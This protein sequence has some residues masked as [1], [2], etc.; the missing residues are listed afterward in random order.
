[1]Q[2]L[3][4]EFASDNSR[5]G[6]RLQRLE[7]LNWGTFGKQAIWKIEPGGANSLLT[8]DIGSGKSTLVDAITTLLV[9]Y[10]KITYNRAAG[11]ETKERS[12]KSYVLGEYKN[13]KN[14]LDNSAKPEYLREE[15]EYTVLLACFF[16]EG[17]SQETT[18]AQVFWLRNDKPE[19]FFVVS[20]R[21]LSISEHFTKFG[22]DILQLKKKIKGLEHT[23]VYESFSDYCSRFRNIFGIRSEK[24]LELFYQT[25]SIKS[26]GNLTEFVRSHMIEKSDVKDKIEEL[27]RN[28]ENLTRLHE[29]VLKAKKQLAELQPLIKDAEAFESVNNEIKEMQDCL[30]ALPAFFAVQK[31]ELLQALIKEQNEQMMIVANTLEQLLA[32]LKK[33]HERELDINAA[34][35]G[36]KEGQRI[37]E[38]ER[39][40]S[41]LEL[42]KNDKFAMAREYGT[43][44]ATLEL[45]A[46]TNEE[47]FYQSLKKATAF[48]ESAAKEAGQLVDARD[49]I[50]IGLNKMTETRK[51]NDEELASLRQRKT[52]IPEA[53]LKLRAQILRDLDLNVHALPFAGELLKVRDEEQSW[54]GVIERVLHNF[55]LSVLVPEEHY[56][57]VSMYV[58]K[59]NLKGRLVYYR[60]P[61]VMKQADY[62]EASTSSMLN[63]VEIKS[64]SR[65]Y[66]WLNN[67]L[68]DNFNYECCESIEQFQREAKAITR[69]G[70]IKGRK[71]RHEKDDSRNILDRKNYILGW[72]NQEK[73]RAI[74]KELEGLKQ[75]IIAAEREMLSIENRQQKYRKREECLRDFVKFTKFGDIYW[76]KDAA[77]IE[78]LKQERK[79]LENTSDQMRELQSQLEKVQTDIED[80]GKERDENQEK[81]GRLQNVTENMN[82]SLTDCETVAV[83]ITAEEREKF[84]PKLQ[85]LMPRKEGKVE[86]ID[87][88]R[89]D[90]RKL[91]ESEKGRKADEEKILRDSIISR[92][93]RYKGT[94]KE[95]TTEVDAS[96]AS[97][98]EFKV[99]FKKLEDEDLPRYESRFKEE[100]NQGTINDIAMF[101]N[102][103]EY[104]AKDIEEKIRQINRSLHAIEYNPGTY[105]ELIA[106]KAI[107]IAVK[108]FQVQLRNCLENTLTDTELYNEEKFNKVKVILDRFN[109]AALADINWTSRVTDVRN[110]YT[111]AA[112][113]RYLEDDTIKEFYPDSSGKSGGQKEKL[114]YT[115][116]ASA[117]AYQFGLEWKQ[118]KSRSFRFVALDEAFGRSSDDST[119]YA[120][121]LFR[122]LD[123]QLLLVTPLQKINIIENYINTV[124]FVANETGDNSVVRDLTIH[125][126]REEKARYLAK[127]EILQ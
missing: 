13:I 30:D 2:N 46:A 57:R 92:M 77:E 38:I 102:Q 32:D 22:K 98:P 37:D 97:I 26:V 31:A 117:L 7:V 105:I 115:I 18:L 99:F 40:I 76:Q 55:G 106:D 16:N 121:D 111:F 73:I 89:D 65:L 62:G 51:V 19:K 5:T 107:D 9:P 56:K 66:S 45:P 70:Q 23:E 17:Y 101:K 24:A 110:W 78:K 3:T 95:E 120:L 96:I 86:R 112:N 11:V 80:R 53:N 52:Q 14:E 118:T 72:S 12:L 49:E 69:S 119:R 109:S 47:V 103:L 79:E 35:K 48:Q 58:D 104:S 6:F 15:N 75:R 82:A 84:F 124:H 93:E 41:I 39:E 74:E 43:L 81:K 25:V 94:Y 67:E 127:A 28:Y 122:K 21:A 36:S 126:Y 34:I 100:L 116:L 54:E 123:L 85:E 61:R 91:L 113:E 50:I 83:T 42:A 10:H 8:G 63:K 64:D 90:T 59:T 4:L 27:K 71:A 20:N 88:L 29:A 114:A 125:E 68:Y 33:L 87:R 1:M 60:I 44:A 108:E